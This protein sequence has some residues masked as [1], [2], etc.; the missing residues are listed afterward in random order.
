MQASRY[1]KGRGIDAGFT[2]TQENQMSRYPEFELPSPVEHPHEA[3]RRL[4]HVDQ[5]ARRSTRPPLHSRIFWKACQMYMP[6]TMCA[7]WRRESRLPERAIA[8]WL[9]HAART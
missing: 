7:L 3:L 8:P 6:A 9:L 2:L 5:F 4:V 1:H